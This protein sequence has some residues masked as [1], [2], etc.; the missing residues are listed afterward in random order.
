MHLTEAILLGLAL[1]MD[2]FTVSLTSGTIAK[3][4]VARPMLAMV[5]LFG[6]FQGGMVVGG[7]FVSSLFSRILEPIDHWIA[8]GL[9]AF[10]GFQMIREGFRKEEEHKFNPFDYKVILTLA[11]ATSIDAMAVGVSM[12]FM[13]LGTWASIAMPAGVIALLSSLLTVAGLA[14]GI[15][16]GRK[17]PFH[18]APSA[19]SSSSASE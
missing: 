19:A 9:L 2:C 17:I 14:A 6:L 13:G 10:I 18:T 4:V 3:R 1:A 12:A 7:W 5:L 15:L 8:F 11:V 16:A